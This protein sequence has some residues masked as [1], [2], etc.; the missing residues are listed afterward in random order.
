[1]IKKVFNAELEIIKEAVGLESEIE[2]IKEKDIKI[3]P[4]E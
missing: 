4:F 2:D 1:M 3:Y